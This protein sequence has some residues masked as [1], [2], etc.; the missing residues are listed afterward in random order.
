MKDIADRREKAHQVAL[1]LMA[2]KA[3]ESKPRLRGWMHTGALPLVIAA[4]AV[5][6]V[7]SP[8]TLARWGSSVYVASALLLFGV[9]AIYHRG[10]WKPRLW[11][12][13]RRF[14]HANIYV[15][16]A[17]TY[18]PFALLYLDGAA[19]VWLLG[20]V[21]GVALVGLVLRLALVR[22]PRWLFTPLYVALGW[23]AVLFVPQFAEGAGRFPAWVNATALS[24]VIAGGVLYTI[25]GLVYAVKRP[26]PS[27]E[28]FGFHE[29]FHLFTVLAFVAHYVA[30]SVVTYSL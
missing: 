2:D 7:L 8:T 6:V 29:V 23:V 19:R 25:G 26:D 12:F 20:T 11:A 5:L 28:W 10:T 1:R 16:I 27:P 14:D 22:A 17:G 13:W 24:L 21:W 30:V 15:F 4:S 3:G 9:S 18:T